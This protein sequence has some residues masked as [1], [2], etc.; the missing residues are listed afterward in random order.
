[1]IVLFKYLIPKNY[2]GLT[3][4]P[5]IF[6]KHH[7][8]KWNK[9]L[10]NHEKIHLKQQAELLCLVFFVWY[11]LE[12]IFRLIQY[13][14]HYNAYKNIC[15]EKEAYTNEKDVNYLQNRKRFAFLK[16]L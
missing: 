12:Y 10:V 9:T 8:N 14:N 13:K 3:I 4:Y 15:F 11:F 1:M 6:L 16:Y 5:F 2:S 7:S